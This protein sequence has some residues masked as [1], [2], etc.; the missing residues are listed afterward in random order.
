MFALNLL[1][2]N[3]FLYICLTLKKI[4]KK[5]IFIIISLLFNSLTFYAQ[6]DLIPKDS[7]LPFNEWSK[8]V[9]DKANTCKDNQKLTEEERRVFFYCNL[10]RTNGDLFARTFLKYYLA[11]NIVDGNYATTLERDLKKIANFPMFQANDDL[12]K[13]AVDHA[14]NMGKTGKIGHDNFDKRYSNAMKKFGGVAENCDYGNETG[15]EIVMS[16][17]VDEGVP[18]LGHRKSILS[19]N[20]SWLGVSIQPHK[21]YRYNCVMSFGGK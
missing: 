11:N 19:K 12:I 15:F 10:A 20:Y 1:R 14:S 5:K 3:S 6:Q 18:S 7:N 17:L 8:D 4:M 16:L 2:I 13:I 21:K 9:I